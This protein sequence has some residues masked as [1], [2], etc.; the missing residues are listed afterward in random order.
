MAKY[1]YDK[2]ALK[3]L[4]I[5]GFMNQVKVRQSHIDKGS[6]DLPTSVYGPNKISKEIHPEYVY[7]RILKK[8]R[9]PVGGMFIIGPAKEKGTAELPPF[10]AGQHICVE[11][12]MPDKLTRRNYCITSS[13]S[14]AKGE[15]GFYQ[16]V[17]SDHGPGH[18]SEFILN[19]WE[20]GNIIRFRA[21]SGEAY[22]EPIRD[23][24][25]VL[26]IGFGGP[27]MSLCSEIVEGNIDIDL[28]ALALIPIVEGLSLGGFYKELGEK[29]GGKIKFVPVLL[30]G[31][32]E[33]VEK[34]P[35]SADLLKK[36]MADKD[37]NIKDM[38][39]FITCPE[40]ICS[41]FEEQLIKLGVP[42]R[43]IHKEIQGLEA[44]I[45]AIK[46]YPTERVVK[47]FSLKV[48]VRGECRVLPC[49]SDKTLA[50]AIE[51]AKIKLKTSCRMGHC[52][53][54]HSRLISGEYFMPETMDGRREADKKFG[55]IHPCRTYPL[56]DMEIEIFPEN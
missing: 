31:E 49:S 23:L 8:I 41:D 30:N 35:I 54:C 40:P 43:R 25:D 3:G 50:E 51:D 33:G 16:L 1:N 15:H 32:V 21:P 18:A 6:T 38:T 37:G 19:N 12:E 20:E 5:S 29:T 17:V 2:S 45:F 52:G 7:G 4:K 47:Q 42:Q 36:I 28:T 39:V 24:H 26:V 44:P 9:M 10:R 34:W 14:A 53:L 56:S 48:W 13:P 22:Y 27:G 11:L 46:S 55:W